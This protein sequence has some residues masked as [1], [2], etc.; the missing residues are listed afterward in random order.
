MFNSKCQVIQIKFFKKEKKRGEDIET[1]HSS[2]LKDREQN[3]H[4]NCSYYSQNARKI[5]CHLYNSFDKIAYS[6]CDYDLNHCHSA[7]FP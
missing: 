4:I 1:T 7:Y 2:I 5:A 3:A 6:A